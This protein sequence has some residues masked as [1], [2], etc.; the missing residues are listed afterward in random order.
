MVARTHS[1]NPDQETWQR[2][3][4]CPLPILRL[5]LTSGPWEIEPRRYWT[6]AFSL[7]S[8][9]QRFSDSRWFTTRNK[10]MP[11]SLKNPATASFNGTPA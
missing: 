5:L 9:H 10:R 7:D 11:L 6:P 1:L 2:P 4:N 8:L 3:C